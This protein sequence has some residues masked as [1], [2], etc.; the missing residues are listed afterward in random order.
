MKPFLSLFPR[1]C[2]R[3]N[4]YLQTLWRKSYRREI[5]SL[6]APLQGLAKCSQE[7]R[8]W[9]AYLKMHLHGLGI[10]TNNHKQ[11]HKENSSL[12]HRE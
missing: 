12:G 4:A 9:S 6:S 10:R 3:P 8:D 2:N 11:V 7:Q 5:E 1:R